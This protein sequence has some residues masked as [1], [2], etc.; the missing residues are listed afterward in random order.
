MATIFSAKG[1]RELLTWDATSA[2]I[3]VDKTDVTSFSGNESFTL[4]ASA[5][6]PG[7]IGPFSTIGNSGGGGFPW[8]TSDDFA[9]DMQGEIDSVLGANI[10]SFVEI[11]NGPGEDSNFFLIDDNETSIEV[12][13]VSNLTFETFPVP[14]IIRDVLASNNSVNPQAALPG[15]GLV[16]WFDPFNLKPDISSLYSIP[17]GANEATLWMTV[18]ADDP[19]DGYVAGALYFVGWTNG[20]DGYVT[21]GYYT[22]LMLETLDQ[23]LEIPIA[24]T[25]TTI[26][27]SFTARII[28]LSVAPGVAG[29]LLA[30]GTSGPVKST[31]VVK[32]PVPIG[33]T[34]LYVIATAYTNNSISSLPKTAYPPSI[35]V[36][37]TAGT[38]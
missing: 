7:V 31:S 9:I 22:E 19:E 11:P 34:G 6:G 4:E 5:G 15:D 10:V 38:R 3:L 18:T 20:T 37:V 28:K 1:E 35:S 30:P 25:P 33:A 26:N 36:A 23:D 16:G 14:N 2:S 32:I 13:S 24:T 27:S 21:D 29:S 17:Q 12:S 8:T